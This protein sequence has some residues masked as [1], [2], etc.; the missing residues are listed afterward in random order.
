MAA[1]DLAHVAVPARAGSVRAAARLELGDHGD[2]GEVIDERARA[3]YRT[4]LVDLEEELADAEAANDPERAFQARQERSFL[5][6]ELGAAVGLHGRARR[7][8]DPAER[9]RKAVTWRI[10]DALAHIEAAHP[11]LGRHLRHSVRTG[12]FCVYDPP[13]P[14]AWVVRS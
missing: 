4:R 11:E 6:G 14:A 3:E 10:R 8:L 9:A 1:V 2:A 7:S 12:A 13:Q 5:L